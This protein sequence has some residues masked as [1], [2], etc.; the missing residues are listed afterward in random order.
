MVVGLVAL[1]TRFE[2]IV[3]QC[4]GNAPQFQSVLKDSFA[5]VVNADARVARLLAKY[6]HDLMHKS[7]KKMDDGALEAVLEVG[8]CF[9]AACTHTHT[10]A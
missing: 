2:T 10:H 5:S 1:H 3:R 4:F 9:H 6:T 7:S 8:V